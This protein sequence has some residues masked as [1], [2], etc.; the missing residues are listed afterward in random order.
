MKRFL[1]GTAIVGLVLAVFTDRSTPACVLAG[2]FATLILLQLGPRSVVEKTGVLMSAA[3]IAWLAGPRAAVAGQSIFGHLAV[4]LIASTA[5]S[6]Y[7]HP[8]AE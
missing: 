8:R 6:V 5:L 2:A 4:W 7:L 1:V 3:A